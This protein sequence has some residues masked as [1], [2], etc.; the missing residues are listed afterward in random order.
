[1]VLRVA[2]ILMLATGMA[3]GQTATP[4]PTRC[5]NYLP[6]PGTPTPVSDT[7]VS[8]WY[9]G[10]SKNQN[11]DWQQDPAAF[12]H[13]PQTCVYPYWPSG[14]A[15]DPVGGDVG[16]LD[17]LH[18]RASGYSRAILK[19]TNESIE[20]LM[21]GPGGTLVNAK[22]RLWEVGEAENWFGHTIEAHRIITEPWTPA[23]AT[24]NCPIDT[25]LA[26][27]AVD[28]G[29]PWNS[30]HNSVLPEDP[31]VLGLQSI[32]SGT[33]HTWRWFDV[34]SDVQGFLQPFPTPNAGWIVRKSGVGQSGIVDFASAEWLLSHPS[35]ENYAPQLCL[36]FIPV[37]PLATF[38]PSNTR[39]ET[40]TLTHTP[41]RTYTPT[42]TYTIT[43][44]N[45]H[46]R[47]LTPT[48]T[49]TKTPTLTWTP[50]RTWTLVPTLT[51]TKTRTPSPTPTERHPILIAQEYMPAPRTCLTTTL[52]GP[53]LDVTG[54]PAVLRKLHI[55]IP[56][57]QVVDGCLLRISTHTVTTDAY[58]NLGADATVIGDSVV[59]L[60]FEN[61]PSMQV[62]VPREE[63]AELA[64]LIG[65]ASVVLPAESLT[66]VSAAT[67]GDF[68][69]TP[70]QTGNTLNLVRGAVT[71]F[72]LT[73]DG[74]ASGHRITEVGAGVQDGDL[75]SW[76][77]T[78]L[79]DV[80][81][82]WPNPTL[83]HPFRQ[84][85]INWKPSTTLAWQCES[86]SYAVAGVRME[87]TVVVQNP[88]AQWVDGSVPVNGML[89][90]RVCGISP[91]ATAYNVIVY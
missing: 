25:N 40:P 60:T 41:T 46:T 24:W 10:S 74:E 22:F 34:T 57:E 70:T 80:T 86:V 16:R 87:D 27:T 14:H 58:G 82:V 9:F 29:S 66:S 49:L 77:Q 20:E 72:D 35:D 7:F 53:V 43:P 85:K 2:V 65:N 3:Y 32:G 38:T 48:V 19:W 52:T 91:A 13:R 33:L 84:V 90:L 88:G 39:T 15:C 71:H 11:F 59:V 54:Q 61:G 81:G 89:T 45:T 50:T 21:G 18:L 79:G 6:T 63:T 64:P 42:P 23:A 68:V 69:L 62:K 37:T 26:N 44:T 28:C 8:T 17:F 78:A 55:A 76:G 30:G 83:S 56:Y 51:Q 1:M 4:V 67:S 36:E 12:P 75:L 47:T 31:T 5:T 73:G